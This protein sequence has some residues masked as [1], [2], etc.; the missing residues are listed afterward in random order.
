M[1]KEQIQTRIDALK[2]EQAAN[3]VNLMYEGAIQD[4][5]YWLAQLSIT[6]EVKT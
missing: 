4:C 3:P 5:Q 6:E 2:K 1:T